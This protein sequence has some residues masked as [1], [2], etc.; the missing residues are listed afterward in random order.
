MMSI[1]ITEASRRMRFAYREVLSPGMGGVTLGMITFMV[2]QY[3]ILGPLGTGETLNWSQRLGFWS[4]V[5]GL[6]LPIC[7]ASVVLT[8][9]I[10]RAR[11]LLV[12]A[13]GLMVMV[14]VSAASC[15]AIVFTVYGIF[16]GDRIPGVSLQ[17]MYGVCVLNLF[18]LVALGY[19]V[20]WLRLGFVR[21]DVEV[22]AAT[23]QRA[24]A[25]RLAGAGS[26]PSA[27]AGP[28]AA[29]SSA[30]SGRFFDRLPDDLGRDIIYLTAS[31]HYVDVITA[32]GST[33]ILLR[34]SDAVAELGDI[35]IRVHRSHWVAFRHVKQ[36]VRR[37]GRTLL[38]LSGDHEVRVG[39]NYLPEVRAA[40]P[41]A[42]LRTRRREPD[43][44]PPT[45]PTTSS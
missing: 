18:F 24:E 14:L 31:A 25:G 6:Q 34:F 36:A 23:H 13:L 40:I 16:E 38:R 11:H 4:L 8:L 17:T 43:Q 7:Y 45:V 37:D 29:V 32:A 41:K 39:R 1:S 20:V 42:W 26:V 21:R 12:V 10:T 3:T 9:Y 19:Y 44:A 2:S 28:L 27:G 30:P 22:H 5:C 15:A 33:S 35:G